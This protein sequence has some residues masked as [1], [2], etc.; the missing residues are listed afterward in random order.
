MTK[1]QANEL[2]VG[3]VVL[4]CL[5]LGLTVALKLSNWEQMTEPKNTLTFK[6]PYQAGI[7]GIKEGWPVTIGKNSI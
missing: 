6:V 2:K 7:G 3:I 1:D 4:V 5:G